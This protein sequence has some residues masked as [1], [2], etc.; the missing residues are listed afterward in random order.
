MIGD[1]RWPEAIVSSAKEHVI[2]LH[3][4]ERK[5]DS[6]RGNESSPGCWRF[7]AAENIELQ[8]AMLTPLHM[9]DEEV[10][11]GYGLTTAGGFLEEMTRNMPKP[12]EIKQLVKRL[13][14]EA[15]NY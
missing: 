2:E 14:S 9:S 4:L 10:I 8:M 13:S 6:L 7:F 15:I 11:N 5:R 12:D 1:H 3:H